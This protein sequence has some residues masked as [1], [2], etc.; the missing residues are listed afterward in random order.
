L[1][2]VTYEGRAAAGT[3]NQKKLNCSLLFSLKT[4]GSALQ[5]GFS[6]EVTTIWLT[7]ATSWSEYCCYEISPR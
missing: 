7:G 2:D 4:L 1:R 3:G 5:F 6:E